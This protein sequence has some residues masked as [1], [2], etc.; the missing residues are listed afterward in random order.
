[1]K[2]RTPYALPYSNIHVVHKLPSKP[3][4]PQEPRRD[5]SPT[6]CIKFWCDIVKKNIC[7]HQCETKC[8]NQ[9]RNE[10]NRCRCLTDEIHGYMNLIKV[11]RPIPTK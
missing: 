8:E 7:C 10:T 1:M 9:C 2:T 3:Y 5:S 6:R 4:H 11:Y